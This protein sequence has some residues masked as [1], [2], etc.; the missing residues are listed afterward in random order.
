MVTIHPLANYLFS[1][2]VVEVLE[3]AIESNTRII[4]SMNLQV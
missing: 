3:F 4:D 1:P 2:G